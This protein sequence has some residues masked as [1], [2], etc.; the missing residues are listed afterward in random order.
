M[1]I[2][3][4]WPPLIDEI[5]AA[6][7]VRG[8]NGV[9]FAWAEG[10]ENIIYNPSGAFVSFAL[11][12][13]EA[14]HCDR[15]RRYAGG[16]EAWWREYIANPEFRLL[17]EVPAHYAEYRYMLGEDSTRKGRRK[18]N[19]IVARR[20]SSP[21]YGSLISYDVACKVLEIGPADASALADEMET[22]GKEVGLVP[23][24]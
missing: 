7:K 17:E 11:R 12:A 8:R 9:M 13:H 19:A 18:A 5:D 1:E 22:F 2:I 4:K 15:Q 20:L 3:E 21:L 24:A 6:F 14:V 10:P 23:A 16:T